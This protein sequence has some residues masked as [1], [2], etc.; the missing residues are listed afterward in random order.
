MV[1]GPLE[2]HIWPI[3]NMVLS[4][5]DTII[6]D[7]NMKSKYFRVSLISSEKTR[8]VLT[9]MSKKG[10]L[11]WIRNRTCDQTNSLPT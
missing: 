4:V 6:L 8:R 9:I 3:G 1:L 10:W 5:M 11:E 2:N 7:I